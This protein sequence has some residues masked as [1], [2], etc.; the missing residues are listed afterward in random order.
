MKD[1]VFKVV[2]DSIKKS[3]AHAKE[4]FIHNRRYF[5]KIVTRFTFGFIYFIALLLPTFAGVNSVN[6]FSLPLGFLWFIIFMFFP[7]VIALFALSDH[8]KASDKV[9]KGQTVLAIIIVGYQF[10]SFLLVLIDPN[11]FTPAIKYGYFI[12]VL[13]GTG[14]AFLLWKEASI[15]DPIYSIFELFNKGKEKNEASDE[16][17]ATQD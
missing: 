6:V 16:S 5:Y 4:L 10:L 3:P 11:L 7:F 12:E 8:E 15:L 1:G 14:L 17:A 9:F 2:L 13:S